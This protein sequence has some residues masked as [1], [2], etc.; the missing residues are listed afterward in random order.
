M[1]SINC[2]SYLLVYKGIQYQIAHTMFIAILPVPMHSASNAVK[3]G[4]QGKSSSGALNRLSRLPG[5]FAHIL[6]PV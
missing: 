3:R 5:E 6:G 1:G 4:G 2:W